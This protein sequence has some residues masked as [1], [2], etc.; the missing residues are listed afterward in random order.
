FLV[1]VGPDLERPA[2]FHALE[3]ADQSVLDAV[4]VRHFPSPG[5][6]VHLAVVQVYDGTAV[7]DGDVLGCLSYLGSDSGSERLEILQEHLSL[8]EVTK[9]SV[10]V[11]QKTTSA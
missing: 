10:D 6:L 7:T 9:H 4:T 8:P 1:A 3:H 2:T 5:F 11:S